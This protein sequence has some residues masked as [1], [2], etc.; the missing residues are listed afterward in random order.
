MDPPLRARE[1]TPEYG[2]ETSDIT[3]QKKYKSQPS[4]GKVMFI[5]F[6]DSQGPILEHYQEGGTT[7]NSVH[8]C[9]MLRDQLKQA[10]KKQRRR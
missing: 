1:Q 5:L 7:V 3:S 10:E 9:E 8:Y 2:V 4:G 6:W